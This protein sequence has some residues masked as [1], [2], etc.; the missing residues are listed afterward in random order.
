[1]VPFHDESVFQV[2]VSTQCPPQIQ[3]DKN[4]EVRKL[5]C[6]LPHS[7]LTASLVDSEWKV[8][9]ILSL[10]LIRQEDMAFHPLFFRP[11][12]MPKATKELRY[13]YFGWTL[14]NQTS[15]PVPSPRSSECLCPS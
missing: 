13:E 4:D 2:F 15:L 9:V 14:P 12:S 6:F 11:W 1:M 7:Q 10:W 5:I 3:V 8:A